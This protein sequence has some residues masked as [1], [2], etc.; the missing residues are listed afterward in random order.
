MRELCAH[1]EC[2]RL[3]LNLCVVCLFNV[4]VEGPIHD[5][6]SQRCNDTKAEMNALIPLAGCIA[7]AEEQVASA[8]G[9]LGEVAA[10]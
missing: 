1:A 8:G 9:S 10:E 7:C 3:R 5:N 2:H 6:H 4:I